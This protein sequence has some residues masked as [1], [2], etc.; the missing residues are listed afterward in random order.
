[1]N[2]DDLVLAIGIA[3]RAR[4]SLFIHGIQGLGKSMSAKHYSGN[5]F[6][7]YET[8]DEEEVGSINFGYVDLR[9]ASME[10][11]EIRGLPDKDI[12]TK[13][14]LYLPP[15]ELPSGEWIN[16]KGETYGEVG[17]EKPNDTDDIKWTLHRGILVLEE[18]NRAEDD[19]HQAIF[20]LVYDYQVGKW[21]LPTGWSV[22]A[23]GN[24]SGGNF[25]VNQF[26]HEDAFKDRF[27]HVNVDIDDDY[28]RS[29]TNYM[30]GLDID[31]NI[32][33]HITQFCMLDPGHISQSNDDSDHDDIIITPSPRSWE[34]LS[35]VEQEISNTKRDNVISHEIIEK[36]RRDMLNG[37][38]G[39]ATA[40]HYMEAKIEVVPKQ[41][42][43]DFSSVKNII[44][45]MKRNQIQALSWGVSAHALRIENWTDPIMDNLISFGKWILLE[46]SRK[47]QDNRDLAVAYF[48]N[49]LKREQ[50]QSIRRISFANKSLQRL[51]KKKNFTTPLW[52]KMTNDK[53]LADIIR[54]SH[55][56]KLSDDDSEN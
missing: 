51:M 15:D 39:Q 35:K 26:M 17:S 24:P 49:L 33:D 3:H 43:E 52:E 46:L 8:I 23:T 32:I 18:V 16:S 55:L 45:K 5:N 44:S 2:I 27:I 9:C 40:S 47:D 29:W 54:S 25:I 7:F 31:S 12:E 21:K 56:G 53:D 38:V 22:I 48:D 13:K 50:K 42:I 30:S 1:M 14:T 34:M 41:I 19:I 4:V 28:M 37:L 10:S 6:H 20:Q 11:S 36:V